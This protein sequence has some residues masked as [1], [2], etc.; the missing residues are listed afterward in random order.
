M[1]TYLLAPMIVLA[2]VAFLAVGCCDPKELAQVKDDY[3]KAMGENSRLGNDNAELRRQNGALEA[4]IR[5]VGSAG[6]GNQAAYQKLQDRNAQLTREL[7]G[8]QH[9][10]DRLKATGM[11]VVEGSLPAEMSS[12]LKALADSHGDFIEYLPKYGMI[13][14]KSDLTFDLGSDAVQAKAA[15]ALAKLA[16][17]INSPAAQKFH[18]YIAGHTDDV[19][20]TKPET[21]KKFGDNWGLSAFRARAVAKSLYTAGVAQNRLA[22]VGFSKYHP[23]QAS[24]AGG[25]A[26][27]R[28]V[29]IWIVTP[30]RLLT[31]PS[32]VPAPTDEPK[33]SKAKEPKPPVLELE[34]GS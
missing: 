24:T 7:T 17:I 28:R 13:K 5:D 21:I 31:V 33:G 4:Q 29:E 19:N 6:A 26:A 27:N 8:L 2:C 20:L 30:D 16:G 34:S 32:S 9:D 14:F 15:D 1:K 12:A 10:F 18:I 11:V 3:S 25:N 22:I 23:V